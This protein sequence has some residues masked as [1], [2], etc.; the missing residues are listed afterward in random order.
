MSFAGLGSRGRRPRARH[1][2]WWAR[3]TLAAVGT[4]A[5]VASKAEAE[6]IHEERSLYQNVL[7]TRQG[8]RVCLQFRRSGERRSQSCKD[9]RRPRHLVLSYTRM[10]MRALLLMPNPNNILVVGL[11][12]GSLPTALAELLPAAHIE[13]CRDR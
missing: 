5:V 3:V 7:V 2:A 1:A 8:S 12:G 13:C 9:E 11:G 4:A 10:M 6:I